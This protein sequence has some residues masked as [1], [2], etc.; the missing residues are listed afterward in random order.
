M[1]V[2]SLFCQRSSRHCV[3]YIRWNHFYH[4]WITIRCVNIL[5]SIN[6]YDIHKSYMWQTMWKSQMYTPVNAYTLIFIYLKLMCG[7]AM[8]C[9]WHLR[10]QLLLPAIYF[11]AL[12]IP[13]H[14]SLPDK[15]MSEPFSSFLYLPVSTMG[16]EVGFTSTFKVSKIF[17]ILLVQLAQLL[18]FQFAKSWSMALDVWKWLRRILKSRK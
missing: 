17:T 11:T 15:W 4:G 5:I 7:T 16:G 9:H 18:V 13:H 12:F 14:L 10:L 1:C 6:I 3:L 2:R 8:W